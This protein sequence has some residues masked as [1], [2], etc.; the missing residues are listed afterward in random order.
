MVVSQLLINALIA[1]CIYMLVAIGFSLVYST[2]R[3]FH[4]AHGA[5]FVLGPYLVFLFTS[6]LGLPFAL[7]ICLAVLGGTT[8]GCLM[9]LCVYRP[10]RRRATSPLILLLASLGLYVVTQNIISLA[11]G[12]DTKTIH[13]GPAREA[14]QILGGRITPTQ[15][16]IIPVSLSLVGGIAALLK[17]TKI[18]RGIQAVSADPQLADVCGVRTD[19]IISLTFALGSALASIAGVLVAL[20]IDIAPT[21]G[22][23]FLMMAVA[24]V[25]V[26]GV[27]SFPGIVLG[28]LLLSAAQHLV[29]WKVGSQWQDAIAFIILLAFLLVR[30][31]GFLGKKLRKAAV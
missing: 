31:E 4:V 6:C 10:L 1:G 14:F 16:L 22:L 20:D 17:L 3:F 13:A 5:V 23:G 18:G 8:A 25:V 15:M 7:A 2:C 27:Q 11:F 12:D 30:P 19:R 9:N 28:S 26:G 29:A 24:A 21:M